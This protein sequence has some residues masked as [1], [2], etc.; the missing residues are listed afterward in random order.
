[1][2][3]HGYG[4]AGHGMGHIA[5]TQAME[6]AIEK[7]MTFGIAL[8]SVCN[9][10]HYG[11]AGVY[12][13][14]A[15][16]EGLIGVSTTGT[17]QRAVVPTFGKEPRFSTNP[18]AFAYPRPGKNPYVFDMA[19]AAKA[20][21][22]IGIAARDGHELPPGI[23]LDAEGNPTTDAKKIHQGGALFLVN[24]VINQTR[25]EHSVGVMLL[26]K[27]LG[28][29]LKEQIALSHVGKFIKINSYYDPFFMKLKLNNRVN[30]YEA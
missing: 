15:R 4:D 20:H 12:S 23:G 25:F 28:G 3:P 5:A 30:K 16:R 8:V 19:T 18:I 10:N 9:S 6:L 1:M 17:T 26:I 14:M 29:S 24:P 7:A 2:N 27:K 21:G 13:N 11:A 22:E